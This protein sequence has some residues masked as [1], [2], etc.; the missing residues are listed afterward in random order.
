MLASRL[1]GILPEISATEALESAAIASISSV[2]LVQKPGG[3]FHFARRIIVAQVLHSLAVG[4]RR[5]RVKFHWRIMVFC[6]WMN[7]PEFHRHVLECL[8]EPLESGQIT[9]SRAAFQTAFP[10]QF[11]LIAA[12][13]PCPCGYAGSDVRECQCAPE[14]IQRYRAKIS[15][16]LLD[17]IDMHVE[18]RDCRWSYYR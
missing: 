7:L 5:V 15:G 9:V 10:A 2:A 8:R 3:R 17:R 11:Q 4:V 18:V 6:F 13:N 16:P 14:Q 12:M 1:P